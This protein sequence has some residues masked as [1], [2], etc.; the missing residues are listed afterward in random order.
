MRFDLKQIAVDEAKRN[1]RSLQVAR[2]DE[3]YYYYKKAMHEGE[4]L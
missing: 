4:N 2:V 1:E 3:A